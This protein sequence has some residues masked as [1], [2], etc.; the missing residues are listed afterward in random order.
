MARGWV[1][2]AGG[3]DTATAGRWQRGDPAPTTAAG[4]RMQPGTAPSGR[5]AFI[6][7]PAAGSSASA[8][9]VDGGRTSVTSVPIV[10]PN[11]AHQKLQFRW[12]FAHDRTATF[13]DEFRVEVVDVTGGG[14]GATVYVVHGTPIARSAAW[15]TSTV[16]L[17]AYAGKTIRVRFSAADVGRN[18]IVEAAF[19]DVRVT[20]PQ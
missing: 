16:D 11:T 1:V 2:N 12:A 5:Y 14:S 9:D 15:R 18:G 20:Q 13:G 4:L 10:L 3:T 7:G 17:S 19:D 8:N 6:T